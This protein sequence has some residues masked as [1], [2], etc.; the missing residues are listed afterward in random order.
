MNWWTTSACLY[1]LP[2][3]I[4]DAMLA[5]LFLVLHDGCTLGKDLT[6]MQCI[7]CTRGCARL[8]P[9]TS[10]SR[11]SSN[12]SRVATS[13]ARSA[14][15]SL[16]T[17]NLNRLTERT[18]G[19]PICENQS[20]ACLPRTKRYENVM[21]ELDRQ[22]YSKGPINSEKCKMAIDGPGTE[23][24]PSQGCNTGSNP[25]GSAP[26]SMGYVTALRCILPMNAICGLW[27]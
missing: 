4:D 18:A 17:V 16:S 24:R 1:P 7:D 25:V 13:S 27:V 9:G 14:S 6:G 8:N 26:K 11:H 5:L 23:S 21:V 2:R 15:G 20:Q 10:R 19:L 12:S 3:E 22:Q